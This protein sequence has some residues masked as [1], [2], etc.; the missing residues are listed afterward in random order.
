MSYVPIHSTVLHTCIHKT[1]EETC[2]RLKS[3]E[4]ISVMRRDPASAAYVPMR[5]RELVQEYLSPQVG[6]PHFWSSLWVGN[7]PAQ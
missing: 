4:S 6:R 3:D 2:E 5:I 7:R 1:L